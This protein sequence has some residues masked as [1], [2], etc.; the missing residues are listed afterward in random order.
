MTVR[1]YLLGIRSGPDG[2][3][4]FP[5]GI[6]FGLFITK[7]GRLITVDFLTDGSLRESILIQ[8]TI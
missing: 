7:L 1:L 4:R 3:T 8:N 6:F 2:N 5:G